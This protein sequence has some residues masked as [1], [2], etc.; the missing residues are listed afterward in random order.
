MRPTPQAHLSKLLFC[1]HPVASEREAI[2]Q[3]S[4][5]PEVTQDLSTETTTG[6]DSILESC[7]RPRIPFLDPKAVSDQQQKLLVESVYS[8]LSLQRKSPFSP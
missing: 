4:K 6:S 2:R 1:P 8:T 7:F 3:F 5:L